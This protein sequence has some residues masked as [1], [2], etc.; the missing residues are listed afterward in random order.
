M[1]RMLRAKTFTCQA[2]RTLRTRENMAMTTSQAAV[3]RECYG[4][5][6]RIRIQW[7]GGHTY[8]TQPARA[9]SMENPDRPPG[10]RNLVL[11]GSSE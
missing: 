8:V 2:C 1:S 3:C 11:D 10:V 6:W 5:G 7:L 9:E 4:R